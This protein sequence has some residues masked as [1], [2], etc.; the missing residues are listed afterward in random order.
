METV[1]K[2][3]RR[4][5]SPITTK[6]LQLINSSTPILNSPNRSQNPTP[7]RHF[8]TPIPPFIESPLQFKTP[9]P[10]KT[11]TDYKKITPLVTDID[12]ILELNKKLQN[13]ICELQ[14]NITNNDNKINILMA[15]VDKMAQEIKILN[16]KFI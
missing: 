15:M 2:R 13:E 12:D 6:E 3:S 5:A 8:K 11:Y 14:K 9:T 16:G 7:T 1:I 10:D 4:F